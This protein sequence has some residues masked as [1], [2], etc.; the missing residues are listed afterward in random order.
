MPRRR[1]EPATG[2]PLSIGAWLL[3]ECKTASGGPVPQ[4]RPQ[5]RGARRP[6]TSGRAASTSFDPVS[7]WWPRACSSATG[8][9]KFPASAGHDLQGPWEQDPR[10]CAR[11]TVDGSWTRS[12]GFELVGGGQDDARSIFKFQAVTRKRSNVRKGGA[13][14]DFEQPR[15]NPLRDQQDRGGV[16]SREM[17]LS[18]AT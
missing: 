15:I 3:I 10:A 5:G 16:Q 7:T 1:R 4:R 14:P 6:A 2:C 8:H 17:R 11:S 18:R 12:L 9:W 13:S